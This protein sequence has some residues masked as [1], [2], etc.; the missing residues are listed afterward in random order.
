M[1]IYIPIWES[2]PHNSPNPYVSTLTDQMSALDNG[3]EFIFD[4]EFFWSEECNSCDIIHIMWPHVFTGQCSA[5]A[6]ADRL[7]SLK[8]SGVSIVSTCHNIKP[9]SGSEVEQAFYDTAY[10]KSDIIIHLADYSKRVLIDKFPNAKHIVIPHHV[11]DTLYSN[12]PSQ[13]ESRAYLHLPKYWKD[14]I[15]C[16]GAFRNQEEKELIR[17]LS[18]CLRKKRI[19]ILAPTLRFRPNYKLTYYGIKSLL[20]R[21]IQ[22]VAYPN[23]IIAG[24]YVS[25]EE[26]PYY[27]GSSSILVIQRKEILNSGNLPLAFLMKKA[28]VGPN[29]GNVGYILEQ[30]EN[31]TF[32]PQDA[33]SLTD[34]VSYALENKQIGENNYKKAI[35]DW[36]SLSI[37]E[38]VINVYRCLKNTD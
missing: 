25:N 38:R 34:A 19:G 20:K 37:A 26:L 23:L 31:P 3:L 11:Y 7:K 24:H 4:K 5:N 33:S 18:V 27:F 21:L 12:Y 30:T 28:V 36:S 32:N 16:I 17:N 35:N 8:R 13:A 9:H 1:I 15:L 10:A 14:Y 6:F 2:D 29:V 22:N